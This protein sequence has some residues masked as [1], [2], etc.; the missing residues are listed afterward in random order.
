MPSIQIKDVPDHVHSRLR[1]RAMSNGKSLQEYLLER[2]AAE[3]EQ[4]TLDEL[5]SR[6]EQH[7]DGNADLASA[8]AA[9]RADRDSR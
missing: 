6:V 5:F 3:A 8:A 7:T 1:E 4:P 9:I 2:L